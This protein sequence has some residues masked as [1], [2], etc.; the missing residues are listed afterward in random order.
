MVADERRIRFAG[1]V[2]GASCG[3]TPT[4]VSQM[5]APGGRGDAETA[6]RDPG[7]ASGRRLRFVFAHH[8]PHDD[9]ASEERGSRVRHAIGMQRACMICQVR[10]SVPSPL[11]HLRPDRGAVNA[12]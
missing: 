1:G 4:A 9:A 5:Q 6:E 11:A 12:P 10:R 3:P 8:S 7:G 2:H